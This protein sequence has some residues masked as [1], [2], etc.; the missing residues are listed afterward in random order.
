MFLSRTRISLRNANKLRLYDEKGNRVKL[1]QPGSWF[2]FTVCI[3][4]ISLMGWRTENMVC[5]PLR[6]SISVVKL[7]QPDYAAR[8]SIAKQRA[9]LQGGNLRLLDLAGY[10]NDEYIATKLHALKI[11]GCPSFLP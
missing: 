8:A 4:C 10:R 2:L 6:S 11:L 7:L 5:K 9:A 1:R 3:V